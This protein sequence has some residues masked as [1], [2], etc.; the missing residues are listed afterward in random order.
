MTPPDRVSAVDFSVIRQRFIDL[1]DQLTDDQLLELADAYHEILRWRRT[2]RCRHA[3][4]CS[5]SRRF[6]QGGQE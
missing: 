5:T 2:V 3:A 1:G 4:F 6:G